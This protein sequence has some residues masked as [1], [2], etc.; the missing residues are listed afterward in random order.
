[1]LE[2]FA[3]KKDI[4]N[5]DA[6]EKK[7]VIDAMKK[8]W[9]GQDINHAYPQVILDSYNGI[10]GRTRNMTGGSYTDD[11]IYEYALLFA[12]DA[13]FLLLMKNLIS[14]LVARHEKKLV[15]QKKITIKKVINIVP[16]APQEPVRR[17]NDKPKTQIETTESEKKQTTVRVKIQPEKG[18]F[19]E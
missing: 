7:V 8:F 14:D 11:E 9:D 12:D 1:M 19:K 18:E 4:F 15:S 17:L 16:I 13:K 6:S 3:K 2:Q 10:Y 5:F